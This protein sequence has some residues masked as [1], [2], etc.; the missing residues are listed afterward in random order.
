MQAA[1]VAVPASARAMEPA[2]ARADYASASKLSTLPTIVRL[3]VRRCYDYWWSI[4]G[5]LFR[6]NIIKFGYKLPLVNT[7]PKRLLTIISDY[8]F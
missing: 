5:S 6:L 2:S 4:G 1:R 8:Y 3:K 7:P